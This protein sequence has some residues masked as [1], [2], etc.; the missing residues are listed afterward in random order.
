MLEKI[1]EKFGDIARALSGK[2]TISEKNV[3][4]AVEQIKLALLD[5]DVNLRVV[6]RF[7]NATLEDAKG[8]K[9]LK[10]VADAF[11]GMAQDSVGQ[12]VLA[13]SSALVK[14]PPATQFVHSDGSEYGAYRRFFQTVPASLR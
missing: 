6:R 12:A 9:V 3:E 1:S 2:A 11:L 4:D 8:E 5:A 13:R 10:A 7:V 14:L